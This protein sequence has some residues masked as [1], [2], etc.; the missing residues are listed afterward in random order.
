MEIVDYFDEAV[1]ELENGCSTINRI[2]CNMALKRRIS[3]DRI[4]D[5]EYHAAR[6]LKVCEKLRKQDDEKDGIFAK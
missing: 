1:L 5:I 4:R 3:P 6:I 2:T